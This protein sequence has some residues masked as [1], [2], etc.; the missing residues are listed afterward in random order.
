MKADQL[1]DFRNISIGTRSS[2]NSCGLNKY[3]LEKTEGQ[4]GMDNPE[5]LAQI[6]TT[7]HSTK[8]NKTKHTTAKTK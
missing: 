5:K 6:G 7:R 8:S 1:N 4:S 2:I 3:T